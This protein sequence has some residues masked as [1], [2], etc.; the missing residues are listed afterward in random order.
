MKRFLL[1]TKFLLAGATVT[2]AQSVGI[3]TTGSQPNASSILDVSSTSKG[4]LIPRMTAAQRTAIA[5]PAKGLLV[6]QDD[7]LSS[8]FYYDGSAWAPIS[9]AAAA[10]YTAGTGIDITGTVLSAKNTTALWNAGQ[11]QGKDISTTAPLQGQVL[12][13]NVPTNKWVPTTPAAGGG[14][15]YTAGTGIDITNSIVSATNTMALWNAAQLQGKDISNVAPTNGQVLQYDLATTKWKP[16]TL[17]AGSGNGWSLTGNTGLDASTN[18]VGTTDAQPFIGKANGAQVFRFSPTG[19]TTL[20]GF[21]AG[22]AD[23]TG[24]VEN[25]FIGYQAGYNIT[26]GFDN[27]FEGYQAGYKNT[28]GYSNQF[29]GFKAGYSNLTGTDNFFVGQLSGYSNVSSNNHFVGSG[30]GFANTTGTNNYFSGKSAGSANTTGSDNHFEGNHAGFSNLTGSNNHFVG[31]NAGYNNTTGIN[32]FFEGYSAGYNNSTGSNNYFSGNNTGRSNTIGSSNSFMGTGAGFSNTIGGYNVFSG[33]L[34]GNANISGTSNVAIGYGAGQNNTTGNG[35]VFIGY[36]AG[37][38]QT[39]SN[40]LYI[41]NSSISPALIYGEFDN[42]ILEF[43]ASVKTHGTQQI[44]SPAQNL[45][46]LT[47]TSINAARTIMKFDDAF[48][49]ANFW[50]IETE[51]SSTGE[52]LFSHNGNSSSARIKPN[53]NMTITGLLTQLSDRALKKNI[54]PLKNPL[55]KLLKLGGY[56]YNWIDAT[57]DK[58]EQIGV[59]AQEVEAQFPQLVLTDKDGIKSVAYANMVP[60]LIEALKEQQSMIDEIKT[61]NTQLKKDMAAIKAKLGL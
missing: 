16:V 1:I 3:N 57:K 38:D 59:I 60:V 41:T 21:Q 9:G 47:L 61:E 4:L 55:Q 29:I 15:T 14:T 17:A 32:N 52:F 6:F 31:Y 42:K 39:G 25:H 56:T 46:A 24:A 20:V 26:S 27:Q 48:D 36:K 13:F 5:S 28:A 8:F 18:F 53:G 50:Q 33:S 51:S 30:A 2:L 58:E 19:T 43:S 7:A 10:V 37:F 11:L 49:P 22:N 40:R 12:L 35:N 23:P 44:I 45:P 34:A 54:T